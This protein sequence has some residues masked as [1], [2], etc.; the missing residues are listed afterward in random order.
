MGVCIGTSRF[1]SATVGGVLQIFRLT[2]PLRLLL[3]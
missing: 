1:V 3:L 2:P